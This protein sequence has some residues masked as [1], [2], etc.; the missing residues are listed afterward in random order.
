MLK[1]KKYSMNL[2]FS[3]QIDDVFFV[4]LEILQDKSIL[5]EL[6]KEYDFKYHSY[7]DDFHKYIIICSAL[8]SFLNSRLKYPMSI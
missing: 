3:L 6:I 2:N 4:H 8:T 7:G 5:G 1:I